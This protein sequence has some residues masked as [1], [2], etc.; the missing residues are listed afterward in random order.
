MDEITTKVS[1]RFGKGKSEIPTEFFQI[2][3]KDKWE[4]KTIETICPIGQEREMKV[5]EQ[6]TIKCFFDYYLY[7]AKEL[8]EA[9]RNMKRQWEVCIEENYFTVAEDDD[10]ALK[11][12]RP[13]KSKF[14][15][16]GITVRKVKFMTSKE[17]QVSKLLGKED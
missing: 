6:E 1:R 12:V 10:E 4:T 5:I 8:N 15:E 3:P 11:N 7:K 16:E 13:D 17:L 14:D 9:T 2:W